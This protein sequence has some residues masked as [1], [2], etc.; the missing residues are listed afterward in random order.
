MTLQYC[1]GNM[2]T[3][4]ALRHRATGFTLIELLVVIAIIGVLSAIG[5]PAYQNYLANAKENA[6]KSN[7]KI[8]ANFIQAEFTKC[9]TAA[10]TLPG[11]AVNICAP[12]TIATAQAEFVTYFATVTKNPYLTANAAVVANAPTTQGYVRLTNNGTT[13]ITATTLTKTTG[14]TTLTVAIIRE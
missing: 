8:V 10:V 3:F 5:V 13:T 7:H 6:V 2:K 4:T 14:G 11:R 9:S 1:K 12:A